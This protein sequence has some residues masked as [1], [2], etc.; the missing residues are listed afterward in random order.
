MVA[1]MQRQALPTGNSKLI[2]EITE[3]TEILFA[4]WRSL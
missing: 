4:P 3:I 1:E 2:S